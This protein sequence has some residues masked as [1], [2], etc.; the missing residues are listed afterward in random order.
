MSTN[1][2][3][4]LPGYLTCQEDAKE[5]EE[6]EERKLECVGAERV[7]AKDKQRESRKRK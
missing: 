5:G 4:A 6:E 3:S 2:L 7:G 1:S